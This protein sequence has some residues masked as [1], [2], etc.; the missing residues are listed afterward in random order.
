MC[1]EG[2]DKC[3]EAFFKKH[4]PCKQQDADCWMEFFHDVMELKPV[5]NED[6]KGVVGMWGKSGCKYMDW[7]CMGDAL[8]KAMKSGELK[9]G[10]KDMGCW[11][12]VFTLFPPC[13][14][15]DMK[16][17]G[18][19]KEMLDAEED[20][21]MADKKERRKASGK[22]GDRKK[23]AKGGDKKDGKGEK[24]R[25]KAGAKARKAMRAE[26]KKGKEGKMAHMGDGKGKGSMEGMK[27]R[28][29]GEMK[30][31]SFFTLSGKRKAGGKG[32]GGK[33][34]GGKGG[35]G[36]RGKGKG[37]GGDDKKGGMRKGKGAMKRKMRR[38]GGKGKGKGGSKGKSFF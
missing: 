8:E 20:R 17:W 33:G 18:E 19:F 25:C 6:G 5:M 27:M 14:L 2:D 29:G 34:K 23:R 22:E 26:C 28:K 16:C 37:K 31:K 38:K 10:K 32:K 21:D 12:Y 7:E 9:C 4:S 30:G 15:D 35:K 36:M 13:K 24:K 3:V 11:V 1:K